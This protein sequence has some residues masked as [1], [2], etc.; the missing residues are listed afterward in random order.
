LSISRVQ[1]V[2]VVEIPNSTKAAD[3]LSQL[4]DVEDSEITVHAPTIEDVF[5]RVADEAK[6]AGPTVPGA[7]GLHPE[8]SKNSIKDDETL[9]PASEISFWRQILVLL[10]KRLTVLWRNFW[11][12][13]VVIIIP[14]AAT[15]PLRAII[16]YYNIPSCLDI[17]ADVHP[18]EPINIAYMS[19]LS[20]LQMLLGPPYINQTLFDVISNF[21]I[22]NGVNLQ[23]YSNQFVFE[24]TLDSFQHH[25]SSQYGSTVP[26]A[27][28]MG[29][30]S[31]SPTFAYPGDV[32]N[33]LPAL[34]VQ[35]LWTQLRTGVPIAAYFT[36]FNSQI[37]VRSSPSTYECLTLAAFRR[38]QH[39]IHFGKRLFFFYVTT[40]LPQPSHH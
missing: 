24:S 12:Y 26:G 1:D 7:I 29:S 17:N 13:L 11:P 27:L 38:R 40:K 5:L 15:P 31:S 19:R 8:K 14:I 10:S 2:T 36:Y 32:Y 39:W 34:L 6:P 3:V 16:N 20:S 4:T 28:F 37:S 22:G 23:N 9:T 21:P 25:L 33:A 30:N 18:V 35:N